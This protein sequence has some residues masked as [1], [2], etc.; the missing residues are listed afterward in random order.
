MHTRTHRH[1]TRTKNTRHKTQRSDASASIAHNRRALLSSV[2]GKAVRQTASTANTVRQSS[3]T[4]ATARTRV[5]R[6]AR[7][8]GHKIAR[9]KKKCVTYIKRQRHDRREQTPQHDRS[10]VDF[11]CVHEMVKAVVQRRVR[12]VD[13]QELRHRKKKK[14]TRRRRR[15]RFALT[16][17]TASQNMSNTRY[18]T[19][20]WSRSPSALPVVNQVFEFEDTVCGQIC[21]E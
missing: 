14:V 1:H 15:T 17:I 12:H 6:R 5:G 11:G 8:R 21:E 9:T 20:R 2:R 16:E 19:A 13:R 4:V 7:A 3:S 18:L 10:H